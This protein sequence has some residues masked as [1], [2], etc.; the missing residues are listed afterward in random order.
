M[1]LLVMQQRESATAQNLARTTNES[2]WKQTICIDREAQ[3]I[4][5][6]TGMLFLAA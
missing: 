3:P 5:V 1:P 2:T 4:D 6:K